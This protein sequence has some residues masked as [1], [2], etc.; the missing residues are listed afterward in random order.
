M[1]DY[2]KVITDKAVTKSGFMKVHEVDSKLFF[3]LPKEAIGREILWYAALA[4]VSTGTGYLGSAA[5]ERSN[6]PAVTSP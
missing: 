5:S 1:K 4:G 6:W 2:D 3:E